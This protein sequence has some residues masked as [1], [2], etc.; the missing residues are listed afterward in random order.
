MYAIVV[1]SFVLRS[2]VLREDR[3]RR[4][5]SASERKREVD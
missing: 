5:E 1:R 2:I 3:V 4:K